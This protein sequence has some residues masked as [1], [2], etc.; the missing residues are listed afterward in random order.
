M[1]IS[2]REILK[3]TVGSRLFGNRL[4][5]RGLG[6]FKPNKNMIC[7][8]GCSWGIWPIAQL[9]KLANQPLCFLA[10]CYK[11]VHGGIGLKPPFIEDHPLGGPSASRYPIGDAQEFGPPGGALIID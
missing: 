5:W 6:I 2:L 9:R 4:R 11:G 3:R 8:R 1:N 7:S 10:Q